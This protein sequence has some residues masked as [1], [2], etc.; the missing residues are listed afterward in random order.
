MDII[1][2]QRVEFPKIQNLLIGNSNDEFKQF[3]TN[4]FNKF[5]KNSNTLDQL[6]NHHQ[7]FLALCPKIEFSRIENSLDDFSQNIID[8]QNFDLLNV[9][10]V[11][12]PSLTDQKI[13]S[14]MC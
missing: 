9:N 3:L 10:Y 6:P 1:L 12:Y 4:E 11:F 5:F 13:I 8:L 2:D 7:L 14:K